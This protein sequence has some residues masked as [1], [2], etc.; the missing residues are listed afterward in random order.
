M[1]EKKQFLIESQNIWLTFKVN[2]TREFLDKV[3]EL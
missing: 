1:I 2:S 3:R